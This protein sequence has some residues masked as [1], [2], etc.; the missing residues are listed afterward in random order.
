VTGDSYSLVE[1]QSGPIANNLAFIEYDLDIINADHGP[2]LVI[3]EL[4]TAVFD[5]SRESDP[6]AD[7]QRDLLS[8]EHTELPCLVEWQLLL[9]AILSDDDNTLLPAKGF[10]LFAALKSLFLNS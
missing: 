7:C 8:L 5:V 1:M 10:P 9:D 2:E 6:V 4:L 3:E